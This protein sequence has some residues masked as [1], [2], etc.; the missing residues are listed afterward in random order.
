M[1][2]ITTVVATALATAAEKLVGLS[3]KLDELATNRLL[4]EHVLPV[5]EEIL[6]VKELVFDAKRGQA[7]SEAALEKEYVA[8]IEN[9]KH[10]NAKL[11][12]TIEKLQ[13]PDQ[14]L[15][16][17]DTKTAIL[18]FLGDG[19]DCLS[20][21]IAGHLKIGEQLA[22]F[23]LHELADM[24][25]ALIYYSSSSSRGVPNQYSINQ[26]GR[27]YLVQHGLLK[28]F[29]VNTGD[30]IKRRSDENWQSVATALAMRG[31]NDIS[32]TS[33]TLPKAHLTY[34]NERASIDTT[35]IL[36][37]IPVASSQDDLWNQLRERRLV[38]PK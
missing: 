31:F 7:E 9:L 22:H 1:P 18:V 15:T 38:R 13:S 28:G 29:L 11:V 5:R 30:E 4:R 20:Y 36:P 34:K 33:G 10:E 21:E 27:R 24:T 23:H 16:L 26:E 35:D 12:A 37:L 17:D 6:R 19:H 8:R 25:P 32:I 3:Q 14:N 2:A